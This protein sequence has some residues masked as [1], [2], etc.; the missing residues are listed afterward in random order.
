MRIAIY[1]P[2]RCQDCGKSV[3]LKEAGPFLAA[4]VF[5]ASARTAGMRS[6]TRWDLWMAMELPF[7]DLTAEGCGVAGRFE[8]C[9]E[10]MF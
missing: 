6:T 10:Q 7:A 2:G 8:Y 4:S 5:F 3:P 1:Y 9:E